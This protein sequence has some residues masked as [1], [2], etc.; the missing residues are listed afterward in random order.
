VERIAMLKYEVEGIQL[1]Y[2]GDVRFLEQ[3]A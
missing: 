1:F 3:F 2:E